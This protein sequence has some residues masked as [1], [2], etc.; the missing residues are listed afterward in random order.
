ML[1]ESRIHHQA[2]LQ[3]GWIATAEHCVELAKVRLIAKIDGGFI[4]HDDFLKNT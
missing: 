1:M 4:R 3:E 2:P